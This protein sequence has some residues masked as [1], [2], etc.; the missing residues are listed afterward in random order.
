MKRVSLSFVALLTTAV[1]LNGCKK[2]EQCAPGDSAALCKAVQ[3]CFA[4]GTAIAVC[5]EGEKDANKPNKD[6]PTATSGAAGALNYDSSK[7]ARKAAPK[8]PPQP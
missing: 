3:E 4:S 5:R 7:A 1:A 2:Q 6:L 8:K